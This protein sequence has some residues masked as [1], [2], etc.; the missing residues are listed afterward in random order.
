MGVRKTIEAGLIL[1]ELSCARRLRR[2][3]IAAP[4][5]VVLRWHDENEARFG[6]QFAVVDR[7]YVRRVRM[8]AHSPSTSED[9]RP[10]HRRAG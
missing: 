8:S 10:L 1:L 7:E 4:P 9:T 2:V 5:S 3:V 6:L